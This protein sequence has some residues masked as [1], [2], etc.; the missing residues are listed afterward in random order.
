[1]TYTPQTWV[2]G[3]VGGTP[4]NAAR[5][6]HIESG[7]ADAH[8]LLAAAQ[9]AILDKADGSSV[10]SL[11]SA[12]NALEAGNPWQFRVEDYGAV[13][14]NSTDDTAAI[15]A[16]LAA[17]VAYAQAGNH[18]AEVIFRPASYVVA[19]PLVQGGTTKGNAQIPLPNIPDTA[20]KLTIAFRGV[21]D[22]PNNH[23]N[24]TAPQTTGT[25]LRSTLTGQAYSDTYGLPSIVGT[26]TPEQ[27][28][29]GGGG[30]TAAKFANL[31][32]VVDGIQLQVPSNPTVCGWD[33]RGAAACRVISGS[34][35]SQDLPATWTLGDAFSTALLLPLSANNDYCEVGVWTAFGWYCG[36]AV[37]EHAQVTSLR[38]IACG[39]G[40]RVLGP[41]PH[42]AIIHHASVE[43]SVVAA[44]QYVDVS[45][46]PFNGAGK[47]QIR[48]NLLDIEGVSS[49]TD[50]GSGKLTG[51]VYLSNNGGS[52]DV[53]ASLL[54]VINLDAFP[55]A[56]TAPAVPAT[57][58]ALRNPFWRDCAVSI[59]GGTVTGVAVD[60]L[61]LGVTSGTV[62]VPSGRTIQLT[63]SS[64][65][66]WKWVAL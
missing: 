21:G 9:L 7:I 66:S 6:G 26:P 25:V 50:G 13:G 39:V 61:S 58:V 52:V 5:L 55:G 31:C 10:A 4:V 8:D 48:V 17:A 22:A 32:V 57:G 45:P 2:N 34:A 36:I 53:D 24:A 60:G 16:T 14:N 35:M 54:R 23:W 15:R 47:G 29:Y 27:S 44:I 28:G 40:I 49:I 33:L 51:E 59:S 56:Q 63:Y 46:V 11:V 62:Y 43:A 42:G 1:M 64:A 37:S 65:P 19:G 3:E 12:V 41:Y 30:L 20:Q 38:S 18:Y